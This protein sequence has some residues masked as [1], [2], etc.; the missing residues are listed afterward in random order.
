MREERSFQTKK[1]RIEKKK[2]E[3]ARNKTKKSDVK[4]HFSPLRERQRRSLEYTET[5]EVSH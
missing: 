4:L 3:K 1:M 5:H 2:K